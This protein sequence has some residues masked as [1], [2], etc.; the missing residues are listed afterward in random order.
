MSN[1]LDDDLLSAV[2]D[3]FY[4][5]S[6]TSRED[7]DEEDYAHFVSQIVGGFLRKNLALEGLHLNINALTRLPKLLRLKPD[8]TAFRLFDNMIQDSGA[9]A[10]HQILMS[11]PQ[12]KTVDIGCNDL[13]DGSMI[14]LIDMIRETKIE[15][16]QLG[17]MDSV[18]QGNRFSRE[19]LSQI[20]DVIKEV[21]RVK[22][23]GLSGIIGSRI[24]RKYNSSQFSSYLGALVGTSKAL[25]TLNV[26]ALDL[27]DDDQEAL[28]AGFEK[29]QGLRVLIMSGNSFPCGTRLVESVTRV[30]TLRS[31][32]MAHCNLSTAALQV[33]ATELKNGWELIDLNLSGNNIESDGVVY[34]FDVLTNNQT[35]VM[36]NLSENSFDHTISPAMKRMFLKNQIIEEFDISKN[37]VGD[38]A[39]YA[40]SDVIERN[41]AL[42]SLSV[43]SCRVTD[44]GA[45]A[46]GKAI[47]RNKTLKRVVLKDNFLSNRVGF[48]LV[49]I[50]QKNETL[51]RLDVSSNQI[52]CFAIDAIKK[53][54]HRNRILCKQ[55]KLLE[56][57]KDIINLSIQKAKIP[58]LE[59]RLENIAATQRDLEEKTIQIDLGIENLNEKSEAVLIQTRKSI[60]ELEKQIAE[61]ES[62]IEEMKTSITKMREETEVEVR[63]VKEKVIY[64]KAR[65]DAQ[66]KEAE[67]IEAQTKLVEEEAHATADS[68]RAQIRKFEALIS[69]INTAMSRRKTLKD[70][71]IPEFPREEPVGDD[72]PLEVLDAPEPGKSAKG[73]R[74][75][76]KAQPK[77]VSSRPKSARRLAPS[78]V[79]PV[80][81]R[82]PK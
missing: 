3:L 70:Y 33:I 22:C 49:E 57:K 21:D 7:A 13:S 11:N 75:K 68:I 79:Q 1:E 39:L 9:R 38:A 56:L 32:N 40:L 16:L 78:K 27:D 51:S 71:V 18:I 45:I 4:A 60:N 52:D 47:L 30:R 76:R 26:A 65:Y 61:E 66:M 58:H 12:V 31:L 80:V 23:V 81:T 69:E 44:A 54:C 34:L 67:T 64:E 55:R 29:N 36:L 24:R 15:K 35:L 19:A 14:C 72:V 41:E 77:T 5:M 46:L 59:Q 20:V 82:F 2:N 25:R 48:E 74:K 28:A 42:I 50:L 73:K 53:L 17:S 10:L 43:A 8:L 6:E 63:T 37:Q 62:A